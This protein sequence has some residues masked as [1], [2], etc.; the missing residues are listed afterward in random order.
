MY[1]LGR[2]PFGFRKRLA[3]HK[4]C[5]KC[6]VAVCGGN[7]SY[8]VKSYGSPMGTNTI[9]AGSGLLNGKI[10]PNWML[11]YICAYLSDVLS[12][13]GVISCVSELFAFQ[14]GRNKAGMT[15]FASYVQIIMWS[16]SACIPACLN[17]ELLMYTLK[18]EM[19][20]GIDRASL[21]HSKWVNLS[22][23]KNPL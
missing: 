18:H 21:Q 8:L 3:C 1:L 16:F 4:I 22:F 13:P 23:N 15:S 7:L 17:G 12:I 10:H 6:S 5:P 19:T 11:Y 9:T 14:A 20:P 2:C